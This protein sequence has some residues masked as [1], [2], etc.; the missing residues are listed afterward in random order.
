MKSWDIESIA[1]LAVL[2]IITAFL[3]RA[4][5]VAWHMGEVFAFI[6]AIGAAVYLWII[7]LAGILP[8][9]RRKK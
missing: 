2:G 1:V 6:P 4:A 9:F 8:L 3:A 7:F 5:I